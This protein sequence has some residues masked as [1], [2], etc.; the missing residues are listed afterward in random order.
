MGR[1]K[2][3]I[4]PITDQ[5]LRHTTFNKR[6]NG[7]IKK[8]AELSMLCDLKLLLIFEDTTGALIQYSTHGIFNQFEYFTNFM[9]EKN[10]TVQPERL[11]ELFQ[12]QPLQK[13]Q[14]SSHQR[15][16]KATNQIR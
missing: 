8:A 15:V 1:R 11:P 13:E 2:I 14:Q 16:R 5:K 3:I 9:E 4:R 10:Y 6:K 7:L 12:S